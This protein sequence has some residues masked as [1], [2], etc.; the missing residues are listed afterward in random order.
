MRN[1]REVKLEIPSEGSEL[2]HIRAAVERFM[3]SHGFDE[4]QIYHIKGAISE[5]VANAIEHGSPKGTD[6]RIVVTLED[7]GDRLIAYITDQG[8]FKSRLSTFQPGA[9]Y[10]GRGLFLMS[11]LMDE[12][13]IK[14]TE[15]GTTLRLVKK[16][17]RANLEEWTG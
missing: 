3:D 6:N 17:N 9:G 15:H 11:A 16:R 4:N 5:A 10:R 7:D 1:R 13:D 12:V 8:K 14:E 2:A